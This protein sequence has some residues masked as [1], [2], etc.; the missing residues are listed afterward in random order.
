MANTQHFARPGL[1]PF[2]LALGLT[3]TAMFADA[4]TETRTLDIRGQSLEAAIVYLGRVFDVEVIVPA[5]SGAAAQTVSLSGSFTFNE[6]ATQ[7][8]LGSGFQ[9]SSTNSG[10]R[11]LQPDDT[12]ESDT[13]DPST[14]SR[15]LPVQFEEVLVYGTKRQLDIQQTQ[16]STAVFTQQMIEQQVQL[17]LEDILLR[18]ANVSTDGSG[19]MN[20][21]SIRGIGLSGVG[22]AGTGATVNVYVD[23][24]PNSFVANQGAANLWDVAQVEVLRGPQSTVQGRN[25]LAGAVIVQT[26]DP[27]YEFGVD[28]RAR[29]GNEDQRQYSA[30][31]TGPMIDDELAFRVAADY[32]ELDFGV[33]NVAA[34]DSRS[35]FQEALT[36]RGKLLY[37]PSSL[38]GLRIELCASYIETDFGDFNTVFLNQPVV[39][40]SDN[41]PS[42]IPG[43]LDDFDIFGDVTFGQSGANRLESLETTRFV[44]D[45]AYDVNDHWQI[46]AL[47]TF[48]DTDR[49]TFFAGALSLTDSRT[50]Q[51]ELRAVFDY[52]KLSG[53]LGAYYFR[54]TIPNRSIFDLPLASFGIPTSPPGGRLSVLSDSETRTENFAMFADITYQLAPQWE[55]SVGA[56][57]DYEEFSDSGVVGE[58]IASPADCVVDPVVPLF[59]GAPCAL[60]FPVQN[61]DPVAVDFDAFLP[62]ASLTY[63]IDDQRSISLTAA[64]GYRAGGALI[65]NLVNEDGVVTGVSR[66]QFDPEFLNNIELAFRSSWMEDRLRLNAN[67]F[68]S[69]WEDQQVTIL[70]PSGTFDDFDIENAGAS[71]MYGAEL[72]SELLVSSE[73][74]LFA[75]LGLLETEFTD[76]PFASI[77]AGGDPRFANLSGNAFNR[78]PEVS[79]SAGFAYEHASGLFVSANLAYTSGQ[80]SDVEN[81]EVEESDDYVL[82]NARAGY[83]LDGFE[84]SLYANNLLDEQVVLAQ[85]L[86]AV[87]TNS[88]VVTAVANPRFIINDPRLYGLELLFSY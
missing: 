57:I 86:A 34:D 38:E 42:L 47:G 4:Q 74:S 60:I 48:E 15:Q 12:A 2:F 49:D 6:A 37:E 81:F 3:L 39:T 28:A 75:T 30:T 52:E 20:G 44:L 76:F 59:G 11:I 68:Y 14:A 7:L 45:A 21:L 27:E 78:A 70:G 64:R 1:F 62:R 36:L 9:L 23:G 8:L 32:R 19:S 63:H 61:S 67:V 35:R 26:A 69:D 24:A 80:F 16:T 25:A 33:V 46:K 71:E 43:V 17:D 77:T 29:V 79:A 65:R 18:S 87:N 83:R 55:L 72:S 73:L 85:N 40:V 41:V 82:V 31:V 58:V 54:E 53:W 84:L 56:R 88:G 5:G 22:G 13:D 66:E 10:S 51:A 50:Y